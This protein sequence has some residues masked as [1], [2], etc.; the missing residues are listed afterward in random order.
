MLSYADA[1]AETGCEIV[2]TTVR[3]RRILFAGFVARL[4][5][6]RLSKQVMFGEVNGG[7]VLLRR[8]RT[9]LD[10]L[11]RARPIV[12]QLAHRSETLDVGSEEAG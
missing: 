5:N 10:G 11:P 1:L 4:D 12:V 6:E 7:K 3:K 8:A 2:E 9:G